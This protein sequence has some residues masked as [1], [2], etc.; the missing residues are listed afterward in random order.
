MH[1][2][3]ETLRTTE[4]YPLS[5]KLHEK[6]NPITE[7]ARD[8]R[9]RQ[10]VKSRRKTATTRYARTQIYYGKSLEIHR[11]CDILDINPG[12]GLWSQKLHDF[13]QPRRHVL[14]EPA[15]ERFKSFLDPL[16]DAPS[17]T[18]KLVQKPTTSLD[19]FTALIN[20]NMFPEQ[21]HVN[22]EDT[23]GQD[24]NTTL[25]VTGMLV[26]DP[27]LPGLAFDSMA[28]QLY[29]LFSSAVRSNDYFHSYGRVRTLF[30]VLS[31]DFDAVIA[32][33]S[34][35][36]MKN[37]AL[38]EM[39]QSM[40][41]IVDGPRAPRATGKGSPG[42]GPQYE[43]EGTVRAMQRARENGMSLPEH[44]R[45]KVHNLAAEIEDISEGTGR[46]QYGWLHDFL[47][48]KH[49]EGNTPTGLLSDPQFRHYDDLLALQA[50][51]P[52]VDFEAMGN[53]ADGRKKKTAS[54]WKGREDHPAREEAH[55]FSLTKSAD[56]AL[57]AKH[58]RLEDIADIGE[59]MYKL[60]CAA[61][62]L[63]DG[64]PERDALLTQIA[65]LDKQWE[66]ALGRVATNF[67]AVP[68]AILDDRISLR[69]PPHPRLQWD[70][71]AF[72]PL[73]MQ[74]DEVWPPTR[75]SLISSTPYAR[76]PG[77]TADWY[78]WVH[79][80]VYALFAS[81]SVCLPD[82]LDKMQ[83]GAAQI[84]DKCPALT[85]PDRGGRLQMK[86]FRVR[87]VTGEMVEQLVQAYRDWPF[88]E[89]GSDHNKYFRWKGMSAG[90][91]SRA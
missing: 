54:F 60:E 39:T 42:R 2:N 64:T 14:M 7:E 28:K 71:R 90:N 81:P 82:A 41:L 34:A 83:H 35:R 32:K 44:R 11:G 13:L 21:T 4:K 5:L 15:Y 52:D 49:K 69:Y 27:T 77:Q 66:S 79:D 3:T 56:R 72:E 22:P 19:H 57:I 38:L 68:L 80:F 53:A 33:T 40:E 63:A 84:M 12:A 73:T 61:L 67:R 30:W 6:V 46:V 24:L 36:F 74:P 76:P 70:R 50:K 29:N 47:L 62:R 45:D 26:W 10:G 88:K 51:Y 23:T 9:E 25:L 16:L 48:T 37:N 55:S 20:E 8:R 89:P 78:E 86:H 43:L 58:Q 59:E 91:E 31:A 85:D 87:L 75:L 18:Y 65:D 1:W 17:S